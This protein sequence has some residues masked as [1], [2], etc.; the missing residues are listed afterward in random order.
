M[1]VP[2]IETARAYA[3]YMADKDVVLVGPSAALAGSGR[4]K[5]I[6][7]YDVV[8]RLNWSAPVPVQLH[9][10]FGRRTDVLYKRLL[11]TAFPTKADVATWRS[12]GLR[13]VVTSEHT[14]RTSNS[15]RFAQLAGA[16]LPWTITGRVRQEII[17]STQNS[18]L[19]GVMAIAHLLQQ[20]I[21]SLTVMNCDFYAGGYHPEYGGIAYRQSM[22]RS[23]GAIANSHDALIQLRY[24]YRLK[25]LD[26]R[27]QFD[28]KL[29]EMARSAAQRSAAADAAAIIPARYASS[30]FPGKPL[31]E[32]NGKPMVLWVCE[33]A[34]KMLSK[35][36]VATDDQR[37]ANAVSE[38]G[39]QVAM[40]GDCMT[41]TDRV[42]QAAREVKASI[43][44]NVQGDEPLTDPQDI[45]AV[46]SAKQAIDASRRKKDRKYDGPT[47]VVNAMCSLSG[48]PHDRTAVKAVTAISGHLLYASRLPI[49]GTKTG[50]AEAHWK[51]LGLYA[52]N[53]AELDLFASRPVRTPLEAAEDVEILRFLEMGIPVRMVQ[54]SGATQAV[55]L[56]EHI[57]LVERLMGEAVAA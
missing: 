30:R 34:A 31:A 29:E 37:I 43:Y 6:E 45:F 10:D 9:D 19:M 48:D 47:E 12:E 26:R 50:T 8:V 13:W 4:A 23:E 14:E 25:Q 32:I 35:V 27:L 44:V 39:Y 22:N 53:R 7:A 28:D 1:P 54:V 24:L 40:T 41:G 38:A 49:P 3:E 57:E 11:Q 21:K 2:P 18:P 15:N 16:G 51:Q 46:V 33:A 52:F 20:P 5:E 36:V 56:P 42:A 17:G 55:D